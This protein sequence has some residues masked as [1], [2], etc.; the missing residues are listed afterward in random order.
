[1]LAYSVDDKGSEYYTIYL[2][3]IEDNKII[4]KPKKKPLG[5]LWAYD[6]KLFYCKLDNCTDQDKF[7]NT[8]SEK[9]LTKIGLYMRKR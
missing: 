4:E 2:R 3:N 7:F 9:N 1:M 5:E 8:L 6:D